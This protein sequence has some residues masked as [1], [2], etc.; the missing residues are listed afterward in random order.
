[1]VPDGLLAFGTCNIYVESKAGLFDESVMTVGHSEMFARKTRAVT[2]AVAQAWE[3]S[4]ALRAQ[5]RTPEDVIGTDTDYLL[6]VTNKD[7]GASLGEALAK[8]YPPGTLSCSIP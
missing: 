2:T 8:M 5:G 3:T 4:A 7:L 6:I 1:K